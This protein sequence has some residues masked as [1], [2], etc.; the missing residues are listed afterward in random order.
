MKIFVGNHTRKID[1]NGRVSIPSKFRALLGTDEGPVVHLLPSRIDAN[2]LNGCSTAYLEK[3]F[4]RFEDHDH[5]DA[6]YN[7]VSYR[8]FGSAREIAIDKDGRIVL[9]PE[10]R[11]KIGVDK[12]V[13]FVGLGSQFA[14]MHPQLA[15]EKVKEA[16]SMPPSPPGGAS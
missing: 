3:Q 6:E 10:L 11:E 5:D 15:E 12:E 7:A 14:L 1:R 16:L 4:A 8:I 2:V 13:A 9:P